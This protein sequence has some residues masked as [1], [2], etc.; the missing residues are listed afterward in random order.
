MTVP[1][2]GSPAPWAQP[3]RRGRHSNR[4]IADRA[5]SVMVR[6][7]HSISS[8][9]R[10]LGG[11]MHGTVAA[12]LIG[13]CV[14]AVL[15]IVTAG[16]AKVA[17]PIAGVPPP[18]TSD[19]PPIGT[20]SHHPVVVTLPARPESY[21]GA[22]AKG[23]PDSYAPIEALA[24]A[25][26]AR[27]T[28]ALYYSGWRERFRSAFAFQ[29]RENGAVPFIQIEPAKVSLTAIVAGVYDTYLETFAT[30]VASYGAKTGGGVIIGFGHEMNGFW[31]PWGYRHTSP[32]VFVAAWR[33]IVTVFRQQGADNVT[34]LW[35][36]NIIDARHG[37]P[38]PAPWWPGSSYVTWVG[39]DGYYL[40]RTWLFASLFGPTIGAVRALT[41]DPILI[42]ETGAAPATGQPAK[43]A[44]LFAGVRA[45]GLLGFVWFDAGGT[46]DWRLSG[47][48]AFA[49]LG[50]GARAYQ[51]PAS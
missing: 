22:F 25:T 16:V 27:L 48:A 41:L 29:A 8:L 20:F 31:Y 7:Y 34:W 32:A 13:V 21:V 26:Q 44:D 36:A 4:A 30:A 24:K 51:G 18:T 3:P 15:A 6:A 39:I 5:R 28:V 14:A 50:R 11:I 33:H 1:Q 43:I 35:T 12:V 38:S 37:I 10:R 49:A 17:K 47:P 40:K 46:Q 45:Y 19:V 23:V 9:G 42:A 2:Q